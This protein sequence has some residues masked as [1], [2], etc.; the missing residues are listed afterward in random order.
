MRYLCTEVSKEII[1]RII[2]SENHP[3]RIV[4]WNESVKK[5]RREE[6]TVI[7]YE[8][9]TPVC[10]LIF[11]NLI[12][13]DGSHAGA[14]VYFIVVCDENSFRS[15]KAFNERHTVFQP[16]EKQVVERPSPSTDAP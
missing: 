2:F 10:C 3:V 6:F 1:L 5:N 14:G 9:F 4:S 11:Q 12:G 16:E 15:I 7:K 13:N 8:F